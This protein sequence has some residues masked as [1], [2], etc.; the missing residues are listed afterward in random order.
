MREVRYTSINP[1]HLQN[2]YV[3]VLRQE[4]ALHEACKNNNAEAVV[5]ILQDKID[6]NCKN[7]VR[8]V[9]LGDSLLKLS[10]EICFS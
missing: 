7:N 3:S 9:E 8:P 6:I 4:I 10:L 5:K 1:L 2:L